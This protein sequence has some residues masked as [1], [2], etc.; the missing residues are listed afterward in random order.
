MSEDKGFSRLIDTMERLRSDSGCEWDR[1][2]THSSLK[3]YL[4]EEAY[5]VLDAIERADDEM[6]VEE[7][8]DLLLQVVFHAQIASERG[9]FD[10]SDIVNRLT[11]KLVRR[12]PHV[13]AQA[14]GY[15]YRQWERIKAEEK[16][17]THSSP[18]GRINQALPALSLARRTVENAVEMNLDELDEDEVS[19]GILKSAGEMSRSIE[20]EDIER[21]EE[22]MGELLMEI[23]RC[24]VMNKIDPERRLRLKVEEYMNKLESAYRHNEGSS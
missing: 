10:S 21:I 17:A 15:S 12:H 2:Q 6:L 9:A 1:E 19:Q 11:D 23:A 22:S 7:L 3:P 5:E 18:V 24:A 4:I 14:S 20:S 8:G 16:G 13:F